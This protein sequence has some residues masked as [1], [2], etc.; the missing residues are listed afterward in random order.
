MAQIGRDIALAKKLLEQGDLVAIPTET[1]YGLAGNALNEKALLEIFKVKR[2]PKFDPLIVHTD[3]IEKIK[4]LVT[5]IPDQLQQLAD[6]FWPG[7]LTLLLEKQTFVPD[8][9]TSGL[10]H[11]AV[12]IPRH[13]VTLDLLASLDFPLAAPSANPFG[14]ISPTTAQHVEDQ[15]GTL[16]PYILDG[17]D[18]HVGLESTIIG[19]DEL[20]RP[21]VYRLGGKKM[22]DI[23]AVIGPVRLR[24]NESSDPSAPGML[25]SHYAPKKRLYIGKVEDLLLHYRGKKIGVISFMTTRPSLSIARQIVLSSTGD[26]DE[27]ASK[28]FGSLRLMDQS[29]VDIIIAERFPEDGLGAAINDRL[30]RA[31]TR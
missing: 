5:H 7:P 12:R 30:K 18:C 23:E 16:I 14:Y 3:S 20:N 24:L 26:V 25:K 4:R 8:L 6:V 9:L 28:L 31:S 11:V 2:R 15:L 17:G 10:P 13:P 1:V 22:E 19:F 29:D 21:V 27:A